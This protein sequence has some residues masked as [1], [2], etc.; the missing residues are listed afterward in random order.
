MGSECPALNVYC[1]Y[2]GE[3]GHEDALDDNDHWSCPAHFKERATVNA[4]RRAS[5]AQRDNNRGKAR[6]AAKCR[7]CGVQT[8]WQMIARSKQGHAQTVGK[9]VTAKPCVQHL[10]K[11]KHDPTLPM[12]VSSHTMV[13]K[14]HSGERFA[15]N[16]LPGGHSV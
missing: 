3:A 8:M 4:E 7:R 14:P 11:P 1:N 13:P 15:Q 2:C 16:L 12:E 10:G 5:R 9:L 6:D